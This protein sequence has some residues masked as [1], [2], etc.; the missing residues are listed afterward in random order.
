MTRVTVCNPLCRTPLSLIIDDSCPVI[1]LTYYWITQRHEW[2][3]KYHPGTPPDAW[4]GDPDKIASLPRTIP[5][6]FARKWGE[7]CGE[8]GIKGK[9]SFIPFP[10]GVGRVDQG[11]KDYPAVDMERWMKVTKE[12]IWPNFDLTPEMLTHTRV[13]DLKTWQLTDLWEQGEWV[14][15]PVELLT[16]YITAA[17]QLLKNAGIP[18]EGVTSPGAF[19]GKKE[20]AHARATLEAALAVNDNPR[21][22]YFLRMTRG[23]EM[24][25]IPI[26]HAQKEKG[27]AIA[28]IFGCAG[29]WF[30]SWTGYDAGDP[31]LFITEDLQGGRLP[32]VLAQEAPCVLVGHWP[33]FYFGGEEVG[34]NVLKEVKRRLDAYDPDG[35][36]TLWMKNSEIGHYWMAKELSDIT[37]REGENGEGVVEVNTRFP[38]ERFTLAMDAPARFVRVNGAELKPARSRLDFR[39]G[40]FMTEGH[41]TYIAFDLKDGKTEIAYQKS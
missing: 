33:G 15:P 7:W 28:S 6:D 11:F 30:G 19:G 21:P 23:E 36:K 3:A 16:A 40:A 2:K 8:N 37:P 22:F 35:T 27:I 12:I 20:E 10:A 29:D 34:L 41:R 32:Q 26:W 1:N 18:C 25:E 31:D 24:P 14:D 39:S 38:S 17:M 9:F 5:A 4:E 13:V